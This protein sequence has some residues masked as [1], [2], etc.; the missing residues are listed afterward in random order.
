MDTRLRAAVM[1]GCRASFRFAVI[2]REGAIVVADGGALP[3]Q[4][5]N[6][7]SKCDFLF[8]LIRLHSVTIG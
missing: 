4:Q 1:V 2:S 8:F 6:N 7:S 3:V 5:E